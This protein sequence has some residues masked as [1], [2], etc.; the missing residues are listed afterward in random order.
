M[1]EYSIK[2]ERYTLKNY[3]SEISIGEA[4]AVA[5][6]EVDDSI[7]EELLQPGRIPGPE[8][9]S[10]MIEALS[11]L[12]TAPKSVLQHT[13][14]IDIHTLF[15]LVKPFIR[16]L[17][18]L[19]LE[20]YK[21][22]GRG[23]F[24]YKGVRYLLPESLDLGD[25]MILMAKESSKNVLEASDIWN[26][27]NS[28]GYKGLDLLRWMTAIYSVPEGESREYDEE[29]IAERAELFRD[30][31]ISICTEVF[32]CMYFCSLRSAISTEFY[33]ARVRGGR[34]QRTLST[35]HGWYT[36]LAL[37]LWG[38]YQKL[39]RPLFGKS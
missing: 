29:R 39:K 36:W 12:S 32:F 1:I 25:S 11:V 9:T 4:T 24:Y 30:L 35:L 37:G 14:P 33:F 20:E 13:Q 6:I 34:L 22:M 2:D 26:M 21:P 8:S 3:S 38:L 18:K 31:P 19:N 7:L 17:Y 28:R 27:L 16:S 5:E 10:Y 15:D 23:D